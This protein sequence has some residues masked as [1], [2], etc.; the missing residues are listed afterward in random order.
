MKGLRHQ[1]APTT[2]SLGISATIAEVVGFSAGTLTASITDSFFFVTAT[3][4]IIAP[5]DAQYGVLYQLYSS[6]DYLLYNVWNEAPDDCAAYFGKYGTSGSTGSIMNQDYHNF[7]GRDD[8]D[9]VYPIKY[10]GTFRLYAGVTLNVYL[11]GTEG[12]LPY[13]YYAR[14]RIH[15]PVYVEI[16]TV[17]FTTTDVASFADSAGNIVSAAEMEVGVEYS[18]RTNATLSLSTSISRFL[19]YNTPSWVGC[20]VGAYDSVSNKTGTKGGSVGTYNS[21]GAPFTFTGETIDFYIY[22]LQYGDVTPYKATTQYAKIS[23]HT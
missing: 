5:A 4:V 19:Q 8:P 13:T 3:G 10:P 1:R 17:G 12:V 15:C 11:Y 20:W 9:V 16:T 2:T 23:I 14:V 21:W 18:L 22:G 7:W 6:T